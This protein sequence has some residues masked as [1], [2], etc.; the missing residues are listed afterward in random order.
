M[1]SDEQPG[2]PAPQTPPAGTA[3]P[4]RALAAA[5]FA[6]LAVLVAVVATALLWPEEDTAAA[7]P[8]PAPT[9]TSATPAPGP[10]PTPTPT[11]VVPYPFFTVGA[12][13][14]HPQ[15]SK[16]ITRPEPRPC[17]DRHDGEAI[18]ALLLP[19]GLAGEPQ[20]ARAMREGCKDV[21]AAA[22]ARQGGGS[23]YGYPMGPALTY[24][25]QGWRDYTCTITA[26]N[27]QEGAKLTAPVR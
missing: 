5:A 19:E 13:F 9:T 6:V 27:R 14:D 26:S 15:L 20:I 12:C 24:Y 18:A 25:Q 10:T 2:R 21:L 16:V 22:Q 7:P 4:S 8:P 23:W 17:T 11:R 1:T 3:R